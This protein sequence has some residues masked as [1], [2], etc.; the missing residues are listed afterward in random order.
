[1]ENKMMKNVS[2]VYT[3]ITGGIY[4]DADTSAAWVLDEFNELY[5]EPAKLA[6]DLRDKLDEIFDE[7]DTVDDCKDALES[8]FYDLWA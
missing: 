3:V 4:S 5:G 6:R 1:M 8:Y 2:K 7:C